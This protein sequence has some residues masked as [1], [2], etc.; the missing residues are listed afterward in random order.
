[1]DTVLANPQTLTPLA[2]MGLV[3]VQVLQLLGNHLKARTDAATH[4]DDSL[5]GILQKVLDQQTAAL[6]RLSSSL[7]EIQAHMHATNAVL[8]TLTHRLE[9]VER[10]LAGDVPY[11]AVGGRGPQRPAVLGGGPR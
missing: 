8:T 7:A 9:Q 2:L 1:M 4:R 6:E 11:P 10:Q 5:A 3:A